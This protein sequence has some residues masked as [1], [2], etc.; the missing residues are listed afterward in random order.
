M[1]LLICVHAEHVCSTRVFD[2]VKSSVSSHTVARSSISIFAMCV[3]YLTLLLYLLKQVMEAADMA[4]YLQM[5]SRRA[6]QL[7]TRLS[8]THVVSK[9]ASA[10]C[11]CLFDHLCKP[12]L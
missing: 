9:V 1:V 8:K 5:R 12:L 2:C 11:C 6:H 7:Q 3:L 10:L 4:C